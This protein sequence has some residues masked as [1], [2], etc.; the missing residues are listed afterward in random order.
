M[1]QSFENYDEESKYKKKTNSNISKSSRKTKHKHQ[2]KGC[3]IKYPFKYWNEIC[4]SVTI[5]SYCTICG[6]IG[7][8]ILH[9]PVTE[10]LKNGL[11][12]MYNTEEILE[13][14]NDLEVF[15][16]C[17]LSQKYVAISEHRN[18]D[19]KNE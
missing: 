15:E 12:R 3:L 10:R 1:N 14:N 9:R 13:M 18:G 19:D 11:L 17:D 2:Y 8:N 16:I 5:A 7:E 6:K 4:N